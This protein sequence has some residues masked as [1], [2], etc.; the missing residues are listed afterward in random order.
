[1]GRAVHAYRRMIDAGPSSLVSWTFYLLLWPFALIFR[2]IVSLRTSCYRYGLP[3]VYRATVP[4][5]SVG[6]LTVGGTGKTPVTDTLVKI[7]VARELRVAV[8]SR[9][10]GGQFRGAVGLVSAGDGVLLM[11][12][13][14]A[15]DEPCLLARRN[16]ALLVFVA[17]ERARGVCAAEAAGAQVIV[18][19]DGF[20]HLPVYRDCDIVLLDSRAPFGNGQQLPAGP[21][22]EAVGAL[23]RADLVIMTHAGATAAQAIPYVGPVLHCRPR[24]ADILTTLD[25]E[26]IPWSRL[27]GEQVV[28]FAGIARPEDFFV[29]LRNRGLELAATLALDDHQEYSG[30]Q[31]NRL[32]QSCDNKKLLLT[33]EKDAVKLRAARFPCPCL[34]VPLSLEFDEPGGLDRVLERVV[35]Q[36]KVRSDPSRF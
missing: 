7:L 34:V 21:L 24:L 15:G 8:V 19:D 17:R 32:I 36:H 33:T 13:Q 14:L 29:A 12:P 31:L 4:V 10:Y 28:A 1:M 35:E 18:L 6:N 30:E 11:P 22:R 25:G 2:L 26:E 20:Q 3:K 9:G 16:P 5:I 23:R 27:E